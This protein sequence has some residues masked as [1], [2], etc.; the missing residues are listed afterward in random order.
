MIE[1]LSSS[2]NKY[3]IC[4][5]L[6][7]LMVII[8]FIIGTYFYKSD[9]KAMRYLTGYEK[10]NRSKED[11]S[12][13]S[14]IYGKKI[15]KWGLIFIFGA[16]IDLFYEGIGYLIAWGI[17]IVMFVIFMVERNKKEK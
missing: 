8:F 14:K 11:E 5:I 16:C 6:D 13:L 4:V 9:G 17:W 10:K 12:Y 15:I 1:L 3:M 2:Y 7:L